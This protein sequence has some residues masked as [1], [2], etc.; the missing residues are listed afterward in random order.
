[1]ID[2]F[3]FNISNNHILYKYET[4]YF[5]VDRHP[6]YG[7]SS[8]QHGVLCLIIISIVVRLGIMVNVLLDIME[9]VQLL[10]TLVT[11]SQCL[12]G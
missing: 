3:I 7:K 2:I 4:I 6:D 12:G 10:I 5:L 11:T 1:M 9:T 8:N